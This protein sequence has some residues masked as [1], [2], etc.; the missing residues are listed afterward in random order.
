[1]QRVKMGYGTGSLQVPAEV[2]AEYVKTWKLLLGREDG[3]MLF[4]T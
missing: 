2:S 4:V 1:M 3:E